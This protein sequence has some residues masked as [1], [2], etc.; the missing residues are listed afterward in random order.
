MPTIKVRDINVYYEIHGVGEPLVLIQGLGF[1]I[2]IIT[3]GMGKST[4][5]DKFAQKYKVIAFDNRGAGRTDM[6][7]VPYSVEMMAEDTIGLMDALGIERAHLLAS[8]MGACIALMIAAKHPERIKGL[9]LHVG[10]HRFPSCR[11]QSGASCG[12]RQAAER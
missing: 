8:S 12:K 3:E 4:Y 2:S 1:E 5:Q 10:F 11:T 9:I 7:D 6:P